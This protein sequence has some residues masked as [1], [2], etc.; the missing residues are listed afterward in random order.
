MSV[1][2]FVISLCKNDVVTIG[3]NKP[4]VYY[5]PQADICPHLCHCLEILS[6]TK[7]TNCPHNVYSWADKSKMLLC[8]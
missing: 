7:V 4:Q 1:L 3:K 5:S 6:M 2:K 8:I